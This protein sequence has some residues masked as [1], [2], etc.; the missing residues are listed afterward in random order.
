MDSTLDE[1]VGELR[2]KFYSPF[3]F[4]GVVTK[5]WYI[6]RRFKRRLTLLDLAS[7]RY[8]K[9]A[10]ALLTNTPGRERLIVRAFV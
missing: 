2:P 10:M 6:K 3:D 4:G 1:R 9:K 7:R 5:P 8:L